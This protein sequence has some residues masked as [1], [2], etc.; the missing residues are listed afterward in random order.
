MTRSHGRAPRGQRIDCRLQVRTLRYTL[1]GAVNLQGLLAPKLWGRAMTQQ[2]WEHYVEHDLIP[3][4]PPHSILIW[5]NLNIHKTQKALELL[6]KAGICV[7]F[8]SRYSPDFN[9]IE[10]VWSKLKTLVR[11]LQPRGAKD[12]R[13]AVAE[14]CPQI[15]P[16]DLWG[17]FTH[18]LPIPADTQRPGA[19]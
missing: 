14:V 18:C 1:I 5:D 12:L 17:F 9:P 6:R 19:V 2:D 8:Q 15:T 10:K 7:F 3:V 11:G 4:L 13:E 16:D